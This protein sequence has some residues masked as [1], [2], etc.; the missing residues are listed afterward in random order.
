MVNRVITA[1][2]ESLS[3]EQKETESVQEVK[4]SSGRNLGSRASYGR[5]TTSRASTKALVD[6]KVI[7]DVLNIID[8]SQLEIPER[9]VKRFE[10]AGFKLRW[11]RFRHGGAEGRDDVANVHKRR[12]LQYTFV[13]VDEIPELQGGL[14]QVQTSSFGDLITVGDLALTKVP[15]E[16]ALA[17][18]AALEEKVKRVSQGALED[19]NKPEIKRFIRSGDDPEFG[20]F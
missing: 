3:S 1:D 9:V 20:D 10:D 11:T 2:K 8:R 13:R 17:H 6:R 14:R 7:N 4:S 19:I 12:A 15:L 5:N 16:Y 18:K